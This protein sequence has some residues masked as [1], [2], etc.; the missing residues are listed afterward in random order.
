MKHVLI[1]HREAL[2]HLK[3]ASH[4]RGD[5]TVCPRTEELCQK[6]LQTGDTLWETLLTKAD[7]HGFRHIQTTGLTHQGWTSRFFDADSEGVLPVETLFY[8][9]T[10]PSHT[11]E[12]GHFTFRPSVLKG[13]QALGYDPEEQ[14]AF[15]T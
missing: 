12:E 3:Q 11:R 6:L 1:R 4:T 10:D 14:A 7:E 9:K 8:Y 13:L 5:K 15:G 2:T